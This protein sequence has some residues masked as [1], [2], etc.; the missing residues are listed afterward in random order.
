MFA[1]LSSGLL[2]RKGAAK[3]AMRPQGFGQMGSSLEDLGWNDMGGD[4]RDMQPAPVLPSSDE[5]D[6][7]SLN[8]RNAAAGL[9]PAHAHGQAAEFRP[10]V[11]PV[12]EP[13]DVEPEAYAPEITPEPRLVSK[14]AAVAHEPIAPMAE[15]EPEP[16]A[17]EPAPVPAEPAFVAARPAPAS[18]AR[19]ADPRPRAERGANGKAAFTLRLDPARHLRLRLACA[20]SGRSAQG[21]VTDALDQA[22]RSIPGLDD[23]AGQMPGEIR[24]RS[25]KA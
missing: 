19:R 3:P 22:L 25:R 17:L 15:P 12:E 11:V 16:V 21:L 14:V 23:V 13:A 7:D 10:R 18:P 20:V 8:R 24:P 2:A 5:P 1:S 4:T 9:T 6:A